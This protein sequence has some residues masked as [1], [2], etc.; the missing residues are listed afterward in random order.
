MKTETEDDP[1]PYDEDGGGTSFAECLAG[2]LPRIPWDDEGDDDGDLPSLCPTTATDSPS[3][4]PPATTGSATPAASPSRRDEGGSSTLFTDDRYYA[5][6]PPSRFREG[7]Y[8][9]DEDACG[10]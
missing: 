3:R 2:F 9:E 6:H 8:P 1:A 10:R 7:N 5:R 4:C